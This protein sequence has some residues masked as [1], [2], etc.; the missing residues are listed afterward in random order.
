MELP[1]VILWIYIWLPEV[2]TE[3][4][5]LSGEIN[6]TLLVILL[7][8]EC[9]DVTVDAGRALVARTLTVGCWLWLFVFYGN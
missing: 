4:S 9:S 8:P 6:T 7:R 2:L 5:T 1:L 3:M